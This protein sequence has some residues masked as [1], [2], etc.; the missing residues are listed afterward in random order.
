MNALILTKINY[1]IKNRL[2]ELLGFVLLFFS[3][4]LL[5]SIVS[6]SPSDPNFIYSSENTE[7]KN[8]AGFYGS[9]TSDFLLQSLGLISIFIVFN[10]FYWGLIIIIEKK[11]SSFVTKIFFTLI[12]I[13][14]G[15]TVLNTLYNDSFWLIDNGNGGFVGR[16]IKENIYYFTPLIENQYTIYSFILLTI[17]FFILSLSMKLNEI[18]IILLFP[19]KVIKKVANLFK[20][21][22]KNNNVNADILNVHLEQQNYEKNTSEEKQPILPFS[23]KKEVKTA[24]N[25]FHLPTINFLEKN[26]D[27]KNKK[28]IDDSELTKNSEFLEK[29]LLD[30]GVD[31]K[32]KRISCGPVVTLYEFEPASGIKVSKIINLADGKSRRNSYNHGNTKTK[33]RRHN[34]YY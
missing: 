18:I 7:I 21:S 32:I 30:F 23:K 14:L 12:Y 19:F 27:L 24:G 34:W 33:C 25:I 1:F 2:I 3:I 11:I 22:K 13:I 10:F 17:V 4:F 28:N 8:V 16:E 6:Y 31:G 5:A 15:T 26:R 29:I 20:K 9:V